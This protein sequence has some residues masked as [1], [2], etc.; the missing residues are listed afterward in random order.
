[1]I[2]DGRKWLNMALFA[3][4]TML[5]GMLLMGIWRRPPEA[6]TGSNAGPVVVVCSGPTRTGGVIGTGFPL[7]ITG[8]NVSSVGVGGSNVEWVYLLD[9]TTQCL[10]VYLYDPDQNYLS[11]DVARNVLDDL[12]LEAYSNK[13]I[14][15]EQIRTRLLKAQK[16]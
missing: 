16:R 2:L 7:T 13:G 3:A 10:V 12:N 9:T 11:L 6:S 4:A 8:Q 1:M 5:L 14:T 15:V